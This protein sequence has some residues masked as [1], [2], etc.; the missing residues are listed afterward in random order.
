MHK[1]SC[2]ENISYKIDYEAILIKPIISEQL[3]V[4][5]VLHGNMYPLLKLR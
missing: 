5:L 3:H 4:T 1:I 2:A